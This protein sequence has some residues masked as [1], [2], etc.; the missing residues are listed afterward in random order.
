[1]DEKTFFLKKDVNPFKQAGVIIV[2]MLVLQ[3]IAFAVSKGGIDTGDTIAWEVSLTMMLFFALANTMFFLN[4]TDKNKYWSYSI[5]SYIVLAAVSILIAT[6]ISGFGI[7]DSGSIK[8]IYFVVT[9]G[10]L[11]FI[12]IIGLMRRIVEI[13]IKQDKKLRGEE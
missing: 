2:A 12:S 1:M 7:N 8:W 11:V 5:T 4:A 10:Y 6:L 9:F 13:A 3:L